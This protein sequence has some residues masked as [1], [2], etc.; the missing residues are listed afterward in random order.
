MM[1]SR[2]SGSFKSFLTLSYSYYSNSF[3]GSTLAVIDF[4]FL[5]LPKSFWTLGLSS[6]TLYKILPKIVLCL[7]H[8]L[9]KHC[10]N[11]SY[12]IPTT[13]SFETLFSLV[14]ALKILIVS[15]EFTI[16][17]LISKILLNLSQVSWLISFA[18]QFFSDKGFELSF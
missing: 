9:S 18:W 1:S 4:D 17:G 15:L 10:K 16:N 6:L 7:M 12:D 14:T 13:K 5:F 3:L 2:T 11:S 8:S